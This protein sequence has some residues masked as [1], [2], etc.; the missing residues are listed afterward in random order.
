M[1]ETL[2]KS[3]LMHAEQ[4]R[5][6]NDRFGPELDTKLSLVLR[7][8]DEFLKRVEAVEA[9]LENQKRDVLQRLST[10]EAALT[11]GI[12]TQN[13]RVKQLAQQISQLQNDVQ[14]QVDR[15]L[16]DLQS[17]LLKVQKEIGDLQD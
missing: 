17:K 10:A 15:A 3:D 13:E 6:L 4:I 5:A 12:N 2:Q 14:T 8:R 11:N 16:R 9:D 1:I 7:Y